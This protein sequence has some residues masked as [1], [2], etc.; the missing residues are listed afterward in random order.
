MIDEDLHYSFVFCLLVCSY[1]DCFSF[2]FLS[3]IS[4]WL[5]LLTL[6]IYLFIYAC[7]VVL[8]LR[9]W[10]QAFSTAVG[11]AILHC[12]AQVSHCGGCSCSVALGCTWLSSRGS[13]ALDTGSYG[14]SSSRNM[15]NFSWIK[16]QTCV[17][18]V[19]RANSLPLSHRSLSLIVFYDLFCF[20][21]FF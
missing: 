11:G 21:F 3:A 17:S 10:V 4:V 20:L 9:C 8:S 18:C 6:F 13:Q 7:V 12:S 14:L 5:F 15:W 2:T 1:T 16:D 19:D